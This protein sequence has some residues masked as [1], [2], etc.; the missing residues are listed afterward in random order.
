MSAQPSAYEE[1]AS[2]S[3]TDELES[4]EEALMELNRAYAI[5]QID[6]SRLIKR[7]DELLTRKAE[8]RRK[9]AKSYLDAYLPPVTFYSIEREGQTEA[10]RINER[11][12]IKVLLKKIVER[13]NPVRNQQGNQAAN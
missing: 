4:V 8:L 10:Q 9:R 1:Q 6:K 2:A 5:N 3:E 7:R 11:R 13:N 12:H